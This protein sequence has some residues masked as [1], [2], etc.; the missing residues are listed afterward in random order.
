MPLKVEDISFSYN[1]EITVIK[2]LNM[3][4]DSNNILSIVGKSGC[5]K[6]TIFNLM[7]QLLTPQKGSIYLQNITLNQ[8]TN[9]I[10][11]LTQTPTFLPFR[12]AF[13]N[14]CLSLELRGELNIQSKKHV[15]RL[16]EDFNLKN[17][18]NKYPHELSGGMKQRIG[19]IQSI[20]VNSLVYLLDEPFTAID[21]RNTEI[22]EDV[23]WKKK[24][25]DKSSFIIITHDLERAV[26]MSDKIIILDSNP[27]QVYQELKFDKDYTDLIPSKRNKH[28]KHS[29]YLFELVK[30]FSEL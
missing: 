24:N 29:Q 13:E 12:T 4:L 15:K 23:I 16:F 14:A 9:K 20:S 25:K 22:I 26:S 30:S 6:T 2:D 11:Y 7:A 27:G 18:E 1:S 5:G 3:M 21:R 17:T 28:P 8:P 19:I 10:S